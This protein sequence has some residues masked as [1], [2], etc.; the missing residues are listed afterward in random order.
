MTL[1]GDRTL[2][3]V[4]AVAPSATATTPKAVGAAP[5]DAA[6]V[7]RS[8]G[9]AGAELRVGDRVFGRFAAPTRDSRL[10]TEYS[11]VPHWWALAPM[12][13]PVSFADAAA[14][15]SPGLA[16][17]AAVD[18]VQPRPGDRVVVVP[19]NHPVSVLVIQ[20]AR[21]RGASVITSASGGAARMLRSLGASEVIDSDRGD[22]NAGVRRR[23]PGGVDA[24]VDV[25][26][27]SAA[28]TARA[29]ILRPRGRLAAVNGWPQL[30]DFARRGASA[31]RV[32]PRPTT[33]RLLELAG[34]MLDHQLA[35]AA[36]LPS[37][38]AS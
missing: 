6:G 14:C 31:V 25:A 4:H 28:V 11:S 2:V 5:L 35:F 37:L 34:A 20:L 23:H 12:P 33:A 27:D 30:A 1:A 21:A 29:Q 15:I 32:V 16:A 13:P 38:P 18:A 17:L 26:G 24:V 7:V 19:G 9:R 36:D 10:P 8:V 22:V 3:R